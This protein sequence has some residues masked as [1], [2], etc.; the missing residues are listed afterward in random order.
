MRR[1]VRWAVRAAARRGARC[2][3]GASGAMRRGAQRCGA[4]RSRRAEQWRDAGRAVGAARG[5]QR[6]RSCGA[7]RSVLVL[8]GEFEISRSTRIEISGAA[9]RRRRRRPL[10][11]APTP[12]RRRRRRHD[13]RRLPAARP[14]GLPCTSAAQ[15]ETQVPR[16]ISAGAAPR[17][18]CMARSGCWSGS[19]RRATRAAR[20]VCATRFQ[21]E[22]VG[23]LPRVRCASR[24]GRAT[25]ASIHAA[26]RG[27]PGRICAGARASGR[28][29]RPPEPRSCSASRDVHDAR[30]HTA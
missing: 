10:P 9:A 16:S 21:P 1:E 30:L 23:R 29:N 22:D 27:C 15:R 25:I 28:S 18:T 7:E 17:S 6:G 3:F 2:S 24:R 8:C 14:P 20:P 12:S 19:G 26:A 4:T 13:A 11:R 5:G